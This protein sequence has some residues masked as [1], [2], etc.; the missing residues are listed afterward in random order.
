MQWVL[1]GTVSEAAAEALRRHGH[2]VHRVNEMELAE[3]ATHRDIVKAA[4]TRQWDLL[5]N[6]AA[7][8]RAVYDDEIWFNRCIVYLQLEGELEERMDTT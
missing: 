6:E 1:H 7:L 4:Q 5:T 8:V 3:G 2:A